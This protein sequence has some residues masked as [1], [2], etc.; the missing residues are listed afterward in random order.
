MAD[1]TSV[2]AATLLCLVVGLV[3]VYW[4]RKNKEKREAQVHRAPSS[5]DLIFKA[6]QF[7]VSVSMFFLFVDHHLLFL[8]VKDEERRQHNAKFLASLQASPPPTPLNQSSTQISSH[9]SS[10]IPVDDVSVSTR[11]DDDKKNK[12]KQEPSRQRQTP[13]TANEHDEKVPSEKKS[14]Q[15]S[16]VVSLPEPLKSKPSLHEPDVLQRHL[17]LPV[18]GLL[19]FL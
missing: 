6:F 2:L 11:D 15:P 13:Q 4:A 3:W 19:S 16:I 9:K 1:A 12:N 17:E 7:F 10:T 14:A 8:R 5:R 18:E